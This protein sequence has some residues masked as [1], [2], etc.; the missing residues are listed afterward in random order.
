VLRAAVER[1]RSCK[2]R[3]AAS[4]NYILL[5]GMRDMREFVA[6][7]SRAVRPIW[8]FALE[9]TEEHVVRKRVPTRR[10]VFRRFKAPA[11]IIDLQPP[12]W[13]GQGCGPSAS[14]AQCPSRS[15]GMAVRVFLF[16]ATS[17]RIHIF[18]LHTTN[19][20]NI[21]RSQAPRST[22][23]ISSHTIVRRLGSL[24]DWQ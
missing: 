21:S 15:D 16:T 24:S 18:S 1:C 22:I 19:I 14:V 12:R 6:L 13:Q 20:S 5:H 10:A 7:L 8:S 4:C 3:C 23:S 11:I 9:H 17:H 2:G